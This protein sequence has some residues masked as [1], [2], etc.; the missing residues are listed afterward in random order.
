MGRKPDI[1]KLLLKGSARQKVLLMLEHDAKVNSGQKGIL[2][3]GEYDALYDSLEKPRDKKTYSE[4]YNISRKV[5]SAVLNTQSCMLAVKMVQNSL[6]GYILLWSMAEGQE[7]A[8]NRALYEIKDPK[9]RAGVAK[10]VV[11]SMYNI[12][13]RPYVDKEGYVDLDISN[14]GDEPEQPNLWS[15]I[16]RAKLELIQAVK[17]YKAWRQALV[18]YIDLTG[19]KVKTYMDLIKYQDKQVEDLPLDWAKYEEAHEY[20]IPEIPNPRADKLKQLY[21]AIPDISKIEPSKQEYEL[22]KQSGE[23][24]QE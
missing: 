2:T 23:L 18:D 5:A 20:F 21:A 15:K 17:K 7:L 13:T 9:Q 8:I 4:L 24:W 1:K 14:I 12:F 11:A 16:V 3:E 22:F 19:F 10:K 6:K